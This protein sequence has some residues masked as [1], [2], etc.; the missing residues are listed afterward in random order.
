MQNKLGQ[1]KATLNDFI[2]M[3]WK[4]KE[5]SA[6]QTEF[7]N[8]RG[9]TR[10]DPGRGEG[11]NKPQNNMNPFKAGRQQNPKHKQ[12]NGFYKQEF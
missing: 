4:V 11:K 6:P 3:P 5:D 9:M 7:R 12:G 10:V 1:M 8:K 2:K